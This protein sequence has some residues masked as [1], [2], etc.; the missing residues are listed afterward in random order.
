[1][2]RGVSDRNEKGVALP[3]ALFALVMLSGLLLA[4]LSMSAMEPEIAANLGDV[5]R[6]R[7]VA[8]SGIEWAFDQLASN[9]NWN[10]IL[11][12]PDNASGTA[13]DGLMTLAGGQT[14][15]APL[16]NA[17]F[18]IFSAQ[19]RNDNQVGDLAL[20]GQPIDGGV[21]G[22]NPTNDTNGVVILT[23]SGT[24][25]GVTRQ[26]QVVLR[27]LNL[28]PFP[29]AYSMP[30][31]QSDLLFNNSAFS[32]DGRDYVCTANC[33][34]PDFNSR[35]YGL[36]ANQAN[37]K[38]GLAVEP[39]VQQ[40][41]GNPSTTTYEQRAEQGFNSVAKRNNVI[42]KDQ[43]NP[44]GPAV[45]GLNTVA[46]DPGL[47][48]AVM[49][50]FLTQLASFSGTT[51]LQSTIACPMVLTGSAGNPP[52]STPT[53]TNGCGVSQTLDLGTRQNPKL[54]YF[55]GE[56]DPSSA[57]T[58]LRLQSKIQGAGI[59]VVEDG[60]LRTFGEFKWDGIV[61]VTGRYVSSIFDRGSQ[62]NIIGATVANET[63]A[64][65]GGGG[66]CPANPFPGTYYDGYFNAT[67]VT[68]RN[69]QESLDNVQRKLL[70]KMST[71]R[72]I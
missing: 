48:P 61:I 57:F 29:G 71:W 65:E 25:R 3:L 6:A 2:D 21:V 45:T 30:G 56:L 38:Y 59:L 9:P 69:S 18:G 43:T 39:G 67:N 31:V 5:T 20:T 58:G 50:N 24:Y 55:R 47:T 41:L 62:V 36:K 22:G 63:V 68:L 11:L 46:A 49:Q 10:Q 54:V 27:R 42:G 4:F 52:T 1:M 64:C 12:G 16:N 37:M 32:I 19:V 7:Y 66:S 28:P 14:L 35:T 53:L 13:D 26:I 40:N 34:N 72:E 15:P 60:D 51:V 70:F 8:E 44:G 23:A 33:T 17:A